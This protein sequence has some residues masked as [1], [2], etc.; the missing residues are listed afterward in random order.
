MRTTTLK[1]LPAVIALGVAHS[2]AEP[3]FL[4]PRQVNELPASAADHRIQYGSSN[5]QF[6]DLRLPKTG[7]RAPVAVVI[8]GGCWKAKHG[9]LVADLDN[10]A[11]LSSALMNIGIATW[12]IEYRRID[13]AG[14]GWPGTFEDVAA[15]VDYL[16]VLAKSYPL[17]LNRVIVIGHS[18][19]GHLGTWAAARHRLPERSP[20]FRPTPLRVI[21]VVNLA[22]PGDLEK[23]L[24]IQSLVC[25]EPA[26]T[27]L[28]GGS[29]S[30]VPDRY[31]SGSPSNLLPIGVKQFLIV[32]AQDKTVPPEYLKNYAQE[33]KNK[34]DDAELTIVEDASHF[35]VV[36]PGSLAWPR[37]K[38]AVLSILR[39]DGRTGER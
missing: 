7:K 34:G 26:I 5:L 29:P 25:G 32:G 39:L 17:D 36:A 33:A 22:G 23:F 14:G 6:G 11:P 30:E 15:A 2:T 20:L 3:Q 16:R 28:M 37:V 31:R 4:G 35:E 38:E 24:P 8:H 12:N 1:L 19:G 27:N 18:A 21:G 13:N 9:D 10:T